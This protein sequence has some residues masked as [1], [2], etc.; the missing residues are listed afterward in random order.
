MGRAEHGHAHS[1]CKLHIS[2]N[3]YALLRSVS[4]SRVSLFRRRSCAD[5][6]K[7]SSTIRPAMKESTTCW[8]AKTNRPRA[9]LP[10]PFDSASAFWMFWAV[11]MTSSETSSAPAHDLRQSSW[12]MIEQAGAIS[13]NQADFFVLAKHRLGRSDYAAR[14]KLGS[15]TIEIGIGGRV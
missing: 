1:L 6:S 15:S 12:N 3:Q 8:R 7:A 5:Q 14:G 11:A 13:V 2:S 4:P 10:I 9:G